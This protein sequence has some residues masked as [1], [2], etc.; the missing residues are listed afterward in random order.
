MAAWYLPNKLLNIAFAIVALRWQQKTINLL[1][2]SQ[3]ELIGKYASMVDR[4]N[5]IKP[6]VPVKDLPD[7]G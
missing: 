5:G 1:V 4:R 6:R 2:D 3:I 7:R